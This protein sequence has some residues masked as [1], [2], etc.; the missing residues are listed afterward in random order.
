LAFIT[1]NLYYMN[2]L[3]PKLLT[4]IVS[5][6]DGKT[7]MYTRVIALWLSV[8]FYLIAGLQKAPQVKFDGQDALA[9]MW[10]DMNLKYKDYLVANNKLTM[11]EPLV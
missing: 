2:L 7:Y 8:N 5:L 10:G 9:H 4:P 3:Y 11:T 6:V 1:G